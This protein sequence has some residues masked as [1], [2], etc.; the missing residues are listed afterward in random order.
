[1]HDYDFSSLNDKEF[2]VLVADLMSFQLK[3]NVERFKPGRDGGVDGRYFS[4][5]NQE[6]IIQCKHWIKSG[7]RALIR[8]VEKKEAIKVK[9]LNPARYIFV[10]SLELSRA[11]KTKICSL[12]SPHV[13]S[14]GDVFGRED[15]NDILSKNS[16]IEKR[17]YKLWMSSTNVLQAI[18]SSAIIGRSRHK[19]EE[20]IEESNRYVVTENH[21][22]AIEKLERIHTVIVTGLPGIGKTTLADQLC[23]YYVALGY[24]FCYIENSL[25]E[26]ESLF[27]ED[28]KQIFYFDD[29]LGRNF[30]LA[31]TSHQDSHI[32]GF[33]KR[34]KGDKNK[35]FVLTSRTNI[36][37]QGKR[38]SDLFGISKI[39]KNE[40]EISVDSLSNLDK[41]KILYNHIWFGELGERYIDEIYKDKNYHKI[42][43]HRNFN[44]RL[45]SFIT[46]IDRVENQ[47]P[48]DYWGYIEDTLENPKD[49]WKNVF[50]IQ[51]DSVCKHIT[52]AVALHGRPIGESDLKR[53]FYSLTSSDLV[54]AV[55]KSF[56]ETEKLLVGA[57]LNRNAAVDGQVS[58]DL[59]NPSIAD[60]V[61]SNYLSDFNYI[62][63]LLFQLKT[64]ESIYNIRSQ[65]YAKVLS[66]GYFERILESQLARLSLVRE[67]NDFDHY[68]ESVISSAAVHSISVGGDALYYVKEIANSFIVGDPKAIYQENIY[69]V[70]SWALSLK[71]I[72]ARS[73]DLNNIVKQWVY[74]YENEEDDFI[75]LSSILSKLQP[76]NIAMNAH[77]KTQYMDYLSENITASAIEVG[78]SNEAYYTEDVDTAEI[79]AYVEERFAEFAL[80]FDSNDLEIV[81]ESCDLEEIVEHN[82]E[83]IPDDDY[84][85]E[86]RHDRGFGGG[87][88]GGGVVEN[89][90]DD[91][92]ER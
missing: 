31:L 55:G 77:L 61:I 41:A 16:D 71:V 78:V 75:P 88:G 51:V 90:I 72:D 54:E 53:L 85:Y 87:G 89:P 27:K 23:K 14:E 1:M 60:F 84:L 24:E 73:V 8:E 28:T 18:I 57:L 74:V 43:S 80:G 30:L 3:Q 36:L 82:R 69:Y 91:L 42:I 67:T 7:V 25:N 20:I 38:L 59:F 4:P 39:D 66:K 29:F 68:S 17:H 35:R 44:P 47:S 45:I 92:F 22:E 76:P 83:S 70:V 48:A 13:I 65:K 50:E 46:D 79:E 63:S 52:V 40:Y 11:D 81:V 58:Y 5:E 49:I 15:L 26:A 64:W 86:N 10:T 9:K 32:I 34:V 56:E 37:N 19:L 21:K 12:F 2:E 33:M 62:D 6:V